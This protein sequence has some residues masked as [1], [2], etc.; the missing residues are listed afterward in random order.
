MWNLSGNDIEQAKE[1]LKGR[2]DAIKARYDEEMKRVDDELAVI[3]KFEREA[4][5]FLSHFKPDAAANEAVG[6]PEAAIEAA[7]SDPDPYEPT[8]AAATEEPAEGRAAM[9]VEAASEHAGASRWRLRL[10]GSAG[11]ATA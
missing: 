3:E 5:E 2:R 1:Q 11:E 8:P 6:G 4:R 9:P 7:A 10:N